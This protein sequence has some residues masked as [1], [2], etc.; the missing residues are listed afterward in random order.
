MLCITSKTS[1]GDS[2]ARSTAKG[3]ARPFRPKH[4]A[5][6]CAILYFSINHAARACLAKKSEGCPTTD[7]PLFCTSCIQR[8][9]TAMRL[10]HG[11]RCCMPRNATRWR[12]TTP[13]L[14]N[15]PT[16]HKSFYAQQRA[17]R[18]YAFMLPESTRPSGPVA[19]QT[20]NSGLPFASFFGIV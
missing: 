13:F 15:T 4:S 14:T 1:C 17:H 20:E 7:S 10:C 9:S 19:M 12:S 18:H 8:Y 11:C 3:T 6:P 16:T 5:P 2:S